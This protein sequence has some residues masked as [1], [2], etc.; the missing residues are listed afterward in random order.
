[1]TARQA[2][3]VLALLAGGCATRPPE[4][5]RQGY[6][7]DGA[8]SAEIVDVADDGARYQPQPGSSYLDPLPKRA[9]AVPVYPPML[10][11]RRLPPVEVVARLIVDGTGRVETAR[12]I[13]NDGD[14][15]FADAVLAAV[16]GWTFYPLQRVT[17]RVVEPLPFTQ[18]YRFRFRQENGRA[19][20]E[21]R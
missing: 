13:R 15:A 2:C 6:A 7:A 10:L 4:A 17:G 1:M 20:V 21:T 5:V 12:I 3:C 18:D 11:D 14:A 8:V 16:R 9:N 19:V